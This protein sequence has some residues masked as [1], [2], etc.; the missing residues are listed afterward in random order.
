MVFLCRSEIANIPTFFLYRNFR[1]SDRN[2]A[3]TGWSQKVFLPPLERSARAS[4]GQVIKFLLFQLISSLSRQNNT[5][6]N[7]LIRYN[8]LRQ[9]RFY[10]RFQINPA[11][12]WAVVFLHHIGQIRFRRDSIEG[13]NKKKRRV[14]GILRE[15]ARLV[16][17]ICR[18][19]GPPESSNPSANW[20][21]QFRTIVK[22]EYPFTKY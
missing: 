18:L 14:D 7:P 9:I 17:S 5:V 11:G 4:C 20:L 13:E 22:R 10:R 21:S 15:E 12:N 19:G 3:K 16:R 2:P 8:E 6:D 1:F